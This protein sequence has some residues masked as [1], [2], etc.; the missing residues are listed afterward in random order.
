MNTQHLPAFNPD[1]Y[2]G[3][4]T[5]IFSYDDGLRSCLENAV[6]EHLA[7]AIPASFSVIA[8]RLTK[9]KFH[10]NYMKLEEIQAI[11]AVGFDINSHGMHHVKRLPEMDNL[12]L[13]EELSASKNI[14]QSLTGSPIEAYCIPFSK[15]TSEQIESAYKEY[16][17]V[18][19]SGY[20]FTTLP[21]NSG[22]MVKSFPLT[23]STT[24]EDINKLIDTVI[25][26]GET[27]ILMLHGVVPDTAA[28]LAKYEITRSTLSAILS[29]IKTI[30]R[31]RL[32]PIRLSDLNA[33][34]TAAQYRLRSIREV[35]SP[36]AMR[37]STNKIRLAY[38]PDE[39]M[40]L[41][42]SAIQEPKT[43]TGI[44]KP[45][46]PILID[47]PD[48][49][50]KAIDPAA[51]ESKN[52]ETI[53][54][55]N[56]PLDNKEI[57]TSAP[58]PSFAHLVITRIGIGVRRKEFYDNH[59]ELARLTVAKS[60]TAQTC[61]DFT[62]IVSIDARAPDDVDERIKAL[63]PQIRTEV[64]R[65]DPLER[66]LNAV[67]LPK[68]RKFANGLNIIT[69]RIDD[70]DLMSRNCIAVIQEKL[71]SC[72]PPAAITF[73]NGLNMTRYGIYNARFPWIA[74]GLSSL[75]A[76]AAT[77]HIY[78]FNHTKVGASIEKMHGTAIVAETSE[79]MW[80]RTIR[81]S[82]DS[83]AGTEQRATKRK[84]TQQFQPEQFG[85][86]FS[87]A[88]ELFALL[89]TDSPSNIDTGVYTKA[90]VPRMILKR[91]LIQQIHQLR[92]DLAHDPTEIEALA[93]IVYLI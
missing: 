2:K 7:F 83:H 66:N 31:E 32:L 77:N 1:D 6:P 30:G 72:S 22:E 53:S 75:S 19:G 85:L 27:L 4:A 3:Q 57:L 92:K 76:P 62:W 70:D 55:R 39:T 29:R 69:T 21:L 49:T 58:S 86:D 28:E 9:D 8:G 81:S 68:M 78:G 42:A 36:N 80:L 13:H 43:N 25:D 54:L 20:S 34:S 74:I 87:E 79:P 64:W 16:S 44:T 40:E 45:N 91:K 61:Q 48:G 56:E 14:L 52:F 60:L 26:T 10:G 38:A 51:Q 71:G 37:A 46:K 35:E 24:I 90:A 23:N 15:A 67:D 73:P 65:I 5:V 12:E 59:L 89:K 84:P 41:P 63:A 88:A 82:S 17:I 93:Q 11:M 47:A 18:R 50:L 33:L